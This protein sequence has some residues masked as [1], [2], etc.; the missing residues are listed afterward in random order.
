MHV[1]LL[2]PDWVWRQQL[3]RLLRPW[4]VLA[5]VM[6]SLLL[7]A[8]LP[9]LFQWLRQVSIN[10]ELSAAI[11]PV[12]MLQEQLEG[13]RLETAKKQTK[14]NQLQ[15]SSFPDVTSNL[16][17]LVA[18][19]MDDKQL[20]IQLKELQMSSRRLQTSEAVDARSNRRSPSA[21]RKA[22]GPV[23]DDRSGKPD[24]AMAVSVRLTGQATDADQ[25]ARLVDTLEEVGLFAS[26]RLPALRE[27]L[28]GVGLMHEFELECDTHE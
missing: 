10:R 4:L 18:T 27:R 15:S 19:A 28:V 6:A 3:R 7:V 23:G 25:L 9:L 22:V 24:S 20:Q 11:R 13:V 8:N 1:N 21:N 2:P 16:M 12:Q 5:A 14:L 26:V 17:G